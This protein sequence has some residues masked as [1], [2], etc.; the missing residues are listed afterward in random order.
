[1]QSARVTW[2]VLAA[3]LLLLAM[4]THLSLGGQNKAAYVELAGVY[5][6]VNH[7]ADI[8][9]MPYVGQEGR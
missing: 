3:F 6:G 5:A 1:M 4:H 2:L 9:W 7:Y 8:G